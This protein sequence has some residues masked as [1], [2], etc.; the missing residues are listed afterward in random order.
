MRGTGFAG[1]A[2]MLAVLALTGCT[3]GPAPDRAG[4]V[5]FGDYSAYL[6]QREAALQGNAPI[7]AAVTPPSAAAPAAPAAAAPGAPLNVMGTALIAPATAP[8]AAT[9]VTTAPLDPAETAPATAAVISDE[10]D[11]EAVAARESI[12][13]DRARLEANRAA[14]QQVEPT[15]L[16][17]RGADAGPNLAAYALAAPNQLGQPVFNRSAI[18]LANHDRACARFASADL[19]Q[20]AF[21]SN[22]GPQRD[23]GNLDPD[24]DGFACSWDPTPFQAV[25]Q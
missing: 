13:S 1:R 7:P 22:G 21:L 14:Y 17:E 4:G 5:G 10:N 9:T 6:A 3:G 15:A 11:F 12:A 18:K 25:R 24:G 2:A 20:T 16:P 23:A 8:A 19:A